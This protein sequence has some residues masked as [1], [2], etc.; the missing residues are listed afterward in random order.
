MTTSPTLLYKIHLSREIVDAVSKARAVYL[1]IGRSLPQRVPLHWGR[2]SQMLAASVSLGHDLNGSIIRLVSRGGPC[3]GGAFALLRPVVEN[4]INGMWLLY[5]AS[6][7]VINDT[8]SNKTLKFVSLATKM[9]AVDEK[10]GMKN[11]SQ[12]RVDVKRL[13]SLTHGGFEQLVRRLDVHGNVIASYT[14]DEKASLLLQAAWTMSRYGSF[15]CKL[16][17][18]QD[19]ASGKSIDD[20][21]K[22]TY[23]FG[24]PAP[25]TD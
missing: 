20:M 11:F 12:I 18:G 8:M 4:Y 21:A 5:C 24:P 1:N 22:S 15:F 23:N 7:D 10:T 13:H 19:S 6:E 17:E 16:C 3:D 9:N 2:K 25:E 14:D